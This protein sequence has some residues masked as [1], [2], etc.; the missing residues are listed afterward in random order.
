[1]IMTNYSIKNLF[2]HLKKHKE[3]PENVPRQK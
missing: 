2:V 3:I 1:M